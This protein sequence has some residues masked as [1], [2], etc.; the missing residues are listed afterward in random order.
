MAGFTD[1]FV[2]YFMTPLVSAVWSTD[3]D[4]ALDYPARYLFRFLEHHG[5]LTVFGSPTWRTVT[6][7]SREYVER[8]AKNLAR[9]AALLAGLRDPRA[10]RWRRRDGPV[11]HQDV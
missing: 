7:G 9:G 1:F 8:V 2:T 11:R 3:P 5:M 4:H 6:G 10:R